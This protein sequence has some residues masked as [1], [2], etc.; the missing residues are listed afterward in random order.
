MHVRIAWFIAKFLFE[1]LESSVTPKLIQKYSNILLALLINNTLLIQIIIT[2]FLSDSCSMAPQA[3]GS[4]SRCIENY[5]MLSEDDRAFTAGWVSLIN[6]T[7]FQKLSSSPGPWRYSSASDL[8][9][10]PYTG[11][12]KTYSG[13]GYVLEL[14]HIYYK[15]LRQIKD[16]R[17]KFWL[18]LQTRCVFVE[19]SLYNPNSNLFCAVTILIE[20][21]PTGGVFPRAEV[22]T[23]RLYRY[24]G[25]FQFFILACEVFFCVFVLYFTYREAKK[26]CKTR[27]KYLAEVWNLADLAMLILCWIAIGYYFICLGLRK[28]TLNLY[29][30]NP[31]KF[32]SFQYLSAWQL[33]FEGVVGVTVFVT[34]LKFIKLFRFNRR[35]FLLSY[36]LRQAS[37]ELSQYFIVFTINFLAFTQ[38]YHFLLGSDYDSFSTFFG[39]ML[40]LLSVLLGKFDI[41]EMMNAYKFLGVVIFFLYMIITNF[42]FLNVLIVIIIDSF[43]VV[44]QQND[45]MQNEFELLEYVTR[46]FKDV[47]GMRTPSK[48]ADCPLAYSNK[49]IA[50]KNTSRPTRRRCADIAKKLDQA[51]DKLDYY[52]DTM[53]DRECEDDMLCRYVSR[54]IHR[55]GPVIKIETVD[56]LL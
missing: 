12:I 7:E 37:R 48:S 21:P 49:G 13:G 5:H 1:R 4:F 19:F 9:G 30:K 47:L 25:D 54:R 40:K 41:E 31:T 23:Y 43:S 33:M 20:T 8:N 45:E 18:D 10:Y 44:K 29:H 15:A 6:N 53:K 56:H 28:W 3:K 17:A 55:R 42:L 35:I 39:S 32:I 50:P 22:L 14:S 34:C 16:A 27:R 51:L 11:R 24:A 38:I 52:L 46:H 26:I 2:F 36:T